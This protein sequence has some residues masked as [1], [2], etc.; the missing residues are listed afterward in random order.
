M[1]FILD[2]PTSKSSQEV[3]D[4]YVPSSNIQLSHMGFVISHK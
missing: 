1:L 2:V 4:K 3:N